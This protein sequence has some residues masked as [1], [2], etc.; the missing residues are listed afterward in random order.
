MLERRDWYY[1]MESFEG[2]SWFLPVEDNFMSNYTLQ[3]NVCV[4]CW[5]SDSD[6]HMLQRVCE[7]LLFFYYTHMY[8]TLSIDHDVIELV[9]LE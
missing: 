1:P 7:T 9:I 6:V 4:Q 5:T 8:C 3:S 2:V